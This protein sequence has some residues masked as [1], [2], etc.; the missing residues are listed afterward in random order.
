MT[1]LSSVDVVLSWPLVLQLSTEIVTV[2]TW[3]TPLF[4]KVVVVVIGLQ[5]D[6]LEVVAVVVPSEIELSSVETAVVLLVESS[7]ASDV[8]VL[9]V[10][11]SVEV[12]SADAVVSAV[13]TTSDTGS[14]VVVDSDVDVPQSTE[15]TLVANTVRGITPYLFSK[16]M[17]VLPGTQSAV[18]EVLAAVDVSVSPGSRAPLVVVTVVDSS[19]VVFDVGLSVTRV[20]EAVVTDVDSFSSE[21]VMIPASVVELTSSMLVDDVLEVELLFSSVLVVLV[22]DV[23]PSPTLVVAEV[24]D[25]V[26]ETS[27]C[28]V[29]TAVVVVEVSF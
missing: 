19:S 2:L 3:T 4:F 1:V 9:E 14:V 10:D 15:T 28:D 29:V 20:G 18:V 16:V 25:S 7:S 6:T 17:V 12:V 21:V 22:A 5:S 11:A 8:V 13:V 23:V 26:F 24:D 27:S